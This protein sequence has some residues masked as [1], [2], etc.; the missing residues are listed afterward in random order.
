MRA[1][2]SIPKFARSME[3]GSILPIRCPER[4]EGSCR[5]LE[6]PGQVIGLS[7]RDENQDMT[8][9]LR[10]LPGREPDHRTIVGVPAL[11][12]TL[13]DRR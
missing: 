10:G 12:A 13:P 9:Q 3:D 1:N 6:R 8:G 7:N 5:R 4:S 11:P 2:V